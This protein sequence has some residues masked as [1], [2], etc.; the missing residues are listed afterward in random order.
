MKLYYSSGA[1]SLVVRIILNELDLNFESEAVDLKTK[2]TQTGQDFKAIN[3]KGSVPALLIDTGELLTENQ[4]ILQ[5][6]ADSYSGEKLLAPV[7]NF[8]RYRTLEC[9]NY[10]STELHKSI[11]LYFNPLLSESEKNKAILPGIIARFSFLNDQLSNKSYLM[12]EEFTLPDA[13]IFVM[14]HW[15]KHLNMEL[16]PFSNLNSLY[17]RLKAHPS[18]VKSLKEEGF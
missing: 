13:Y 18:V 16:A 6:L 4:V 15:A 9:L 3:S 1:C 17:E 7:P 12:G 11:G 5:F 14:I 2:K 8:K 10:I